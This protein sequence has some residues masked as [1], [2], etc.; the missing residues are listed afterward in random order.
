RPPYCR[1]VLALFLRPRYLVVWLL[2]AVVAAGCGVAGYWQ[3]QR[4]HEKHAANVELRSN[5]KGAPIDVQDL[6]P[7][8]SSPDA[9]SAAKDAKFRQVSAT[10]V[11]DPAGEVVVRGQTVGSTDEGAGE[12]GFLVLTP[13]RLQSGETA[14]VGRGFIKATQ[15]ATATPVV[16]A[17]PTSQVSVTARVMPAE[18]KH[19][20][21]GELPQRQVDSINSADAR[22]RLGTPV[23]AGYLELEADQPGGSGLT[24]IPAPDLSNPAGGAIEPQHLAYVIQ[25]FVFALL[26][27]I[28]P[29]VLARADLRVSTAPRASRPTG[30]R[31]LS[32]TSGAQPAPLGDEALD[33]EALDDDAHAAEDRA[34]NDRR[35]AK[36]A[37]RYGR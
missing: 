13:L 3:W 31:R 21:Y 1:G 25:W 5:S 9:V 24:A 7:D 29:F 33:D 18:S 37:D 10:G 27:L 23:L 34:D 26:A 4:L 6:L 2:V 36:L 15:D 20:K 11:Y 28:L 22:T 30:P 12:L 8:A 17:P 16:P 19:D 14:L 35:A 32:A